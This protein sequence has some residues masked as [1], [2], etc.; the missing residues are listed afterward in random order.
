M[1]TLSIRYRQI[2]GLGA[3]NFKAFRFSNQ[4]LKQKAVVNELR[5][6]EDERR[7]VIL[8]QCSVQASVVVE[9]S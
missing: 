2:I 4:K 8:M 9:E 3:K 7:R 1:N 6:N 5:A